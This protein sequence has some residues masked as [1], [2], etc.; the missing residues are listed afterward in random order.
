MKCLCP[1]S[2]SSK[3]ILDVLVAFTTFTTFTTLD[4]ILYVFDL[5]E[6]PGY[7]ALFCPFL[8]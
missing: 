3:E 7:S 5:A 2:I 4:G 6:P 8:V 1:E